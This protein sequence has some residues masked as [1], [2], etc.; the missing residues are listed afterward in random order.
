MSSANKITIESCIYNNYDEKLEIT[1]R[2]K[3]LVGSDDIK[4]INA[5]IKSI[6]EVFIKYSNNA[7]EAKEIK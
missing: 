7:K 5:A 6:E 2:V 1:F 4:T 3:D